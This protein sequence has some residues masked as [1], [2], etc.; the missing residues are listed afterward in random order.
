VTENLI[1]TLF[2]YD[3]DKDLFFKAILEKLNCQEKREK[4]LKYLENYPY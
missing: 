2:F 4:A 1:K 3:F